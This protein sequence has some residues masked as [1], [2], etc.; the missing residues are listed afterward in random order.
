MSEI[1]GTAAWKRIRK[2]ILADA[3]CCSLCGREFDPD[4]PPRSP[5]SKAVDHV[6]ARKHMR[7][8]DPAERREL[9]LDPAN[10]RPVCG[11]CNSR[12][13]NASRRGLD[14]AGHVSRSSD[15]W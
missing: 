9:I 12:R 8:L 15:E 11:S 10:C 14:F 3:T 5:G 1:L 7:E 4:A 2:A 6:V 13:E